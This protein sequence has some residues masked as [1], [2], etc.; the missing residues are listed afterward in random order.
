MRDLHIERDPNQAPRT[1]A[2]ATGHRSHRIP[3]LQV[4]RFGLVSVLH[5]QIPFGCIHNGQAFS[6]RSQVGKV[7]QP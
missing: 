7:M 6:H 4:S 1:Q 5:T 2:S 3:S